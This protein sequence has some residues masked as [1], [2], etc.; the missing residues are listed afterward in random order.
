MTRRMRVEA[1]D[2]RVRVYSCFVC[3]SRYPDSAQA[4]ARDEDLSYLR[5]VTTATA[6]KGSARMHAAV[7]KDDSARFRRRFN[8]E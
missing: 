6:G 8:H 1:A 3:A 2:E 7:G 4:E 5:K